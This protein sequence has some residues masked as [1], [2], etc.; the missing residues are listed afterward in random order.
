[1]SVLRLVQIYCDWCGYRFDFETLASASDQLSQAKI[2][3]WVRK[4]KERDMCPNCVMKRNG[5]E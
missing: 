4:S 1:M 2:E 5:E 3:G